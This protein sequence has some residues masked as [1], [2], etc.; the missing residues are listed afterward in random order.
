MDKK[1]RVEI[2]MPKSL[3]EKIDKYQKNNSISTRTSAILELLREGL[4]N[5][6]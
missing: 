4:K 6:P 1:E 3:L 5:N 2:R